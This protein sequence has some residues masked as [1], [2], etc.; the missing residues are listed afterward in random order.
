MNDHSKRA[1]CASETFLSIQIV[2]GLQGLGE[3]KEVAAWVPGVRWGA[4][5]AFDTAAVAFVF[6]PVARHLG[7]LSAPR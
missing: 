4:G 6:S 5:V 1:E 2:L 7:Y 3:L